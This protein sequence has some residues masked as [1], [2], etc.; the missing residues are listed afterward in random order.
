MTKS[1]S[2][3]YNY[4]SVSHAQSLLSYLVR[5]MRSQ[6]AAV[7][8]SPQ[9]RITLMG[10]VCLCVGLMQTTGII[11]ANANTTVDMY[12]IYA[13]MKVISSK[14]YTCLNTLWDKESHW[15]PKANNKKSTAYG[16]PQLLNM[17]EKDPFKQIDLGLKYLDARF[18]GDIC[19]ALSHH[20]RMGYY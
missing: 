14:Q 1:L 4:F 16:I 18:N 7:A 15:N 19:L 6:R 13:H 8:Y 10:R 9:A 5:F 12:K 17:K 3:R 20:K 2:N 11:S